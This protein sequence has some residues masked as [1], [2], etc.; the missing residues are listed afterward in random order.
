MKNS[1]ETAGTNRRELIKTITQNLSILLLIIGSSTF[2]QTPEQQKIIDKAMKMQD[3]IMQCITLEEMLQ[4]A[5]QQEQRVESDKNSDTNPTSETIK[6]ED[7]YWK[8]TLVSDANSKL[9]GWNNGAADLVFNY[10]YDP[11]KDKVEYVK[12]GNIKADG[13]IELNPINEIPILKPLNNFKN[14]NTFFDIH[15]PDSYQLTNEDSGFKLNSYV[16]VYQNEKQIGLLTIGNSEKVTLNLL[17]SGDLYFGD[18]GYILSWVFVDE[19]CA[20]KANENWI[21]D[22]SNTG[23]PLVVETQVVYNLNF[24]PGWN[25]VKTEVIG[26][27]EFP[28]APEEDRSRYKKHEHTS[29]SSIPIDATYYFRKSPQY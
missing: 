19:A 12:V 13:T 28:S 4:Q 25:L 17:T 9:K 26:T 18:E 16:L 5:K 14:S 8:N 7:K 2:A 23:N 10:Y 22:L 11:R 1:K 15:N 29:I 24:N 27:Y 3:S 6:K 21:G 20:I